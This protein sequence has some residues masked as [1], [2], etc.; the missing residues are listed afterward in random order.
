MGGLFLREVCHQIPEKIEHVITIGSPFANIHAPNNAQWVF[1]LLNGDEEVDQKLL[2]RLH[3]PTPMPSTA[4]Y[5]KQDG[6]IPW[7]ACMDL[8]TDNDHNNVEVKSSHFGMG[9][10]PSVLMAIEN[11]LIPKG[12]SMNKFIG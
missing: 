6:V 11:A 7:Q 10:N 9:A 5:S 1:N 8:V 12:T 4:L 3:K 2:S